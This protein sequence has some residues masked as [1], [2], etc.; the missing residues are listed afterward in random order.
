MGL[1]KLVR[2]TTRDG[3]EQWVCVHIEIQGQHEVDFPERLFVYNY[4]IYDRY[5]RP[6]ATLA[7]LADTSPSWKPSGFGYRRFGYEVAIRF[8]V[9]KLMDYQDRLDALLGN[10]NLFA[11]VSAAHLLT[12]QTRG[13]DLGRYDAKWRLARLLY[14]RNWERQR[15]IDLFAV[16]DWMMR[17]P[18][19]LQRGLWQKL[20][21]LERN[22]HMPY[23]TSVERIGIEKGLKQLLRFRWK[24][25]FPCLVIVVN[26]AW[27]SDIEKEAQ[28]VHTRGEGR[29]HPAA[30]VGWY[31]GVR[32][33]RRARFE[34][35]GVL[36]LAEG[37]LCGRRS[38]VC[39]GVQPPGQW[40][41]AALG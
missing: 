18:D 41:E 14:K 30:S 16:L 23:V 13:N 27:E 25:T 15:I 38:G 31:G 34:P 37:I 35:D 5:R 17:L 11:L 24:R 1:D 26:Q 6:V 2:V 21:H 3:D 33:V 12:Q 20:S 10:D 29:D 8:P 22:R 9:A 39:Q 32:P 19:D 36:P 4:R 7:V 28:G 40:S